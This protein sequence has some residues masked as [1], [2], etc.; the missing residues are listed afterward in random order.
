RTGNWTV[1]WSRTRGAAP[2][3]PLAAR[4]QD[5]L[6]T[7][8]R[9][10]VPHP[11]RVGRLRGGP[12]ARSAWRGDGPRP[13]GWTAR[14]PEHPVA[15]RQTVRA[16]DGRGTKGATRARSFLRIPGPDD[17]ALPDLLSVEAAIRP[18]ER[19][20]AGGPLSRPDRVLPPP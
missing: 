20:I 5:G 12:S 11:R 19:P 15:E 2:Q 6:V 1:P 13:A 10:A 9:P 17:P 8:G 14:H 18:E 7:Q 4:R 3:G 16:H